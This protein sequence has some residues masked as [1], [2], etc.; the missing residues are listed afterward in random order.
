MD[1]FLRTIQAVWKYKGKVLASIVCAVF[2]SALWSLNFSA[3]YPIIKVLF[4]NDSLQS[5]V[6]TDIVRV[7][8]EIDEYNR[9]LAESSDTNLEHRDRLLKKLHTSSA[10]LMDRKWFKSKILPW[11]PNEK[12]NTVVVILCALIV[13]TLMKG[14]FLYIQEL[15][16]GSF[17]FHT[18]N[19]I[20]KNAFDNCS[21]LDIQSLQ[22][23]GTAEV[24]S[25]LTNDVTVMSD[26]YRLCGTVLIR[27]PLK[28]ICCVVAAMWFNWRLTS[29]SILTLPL[30]GLVFYQTGRRLRRVAIG[31]MER[32]GNIY[33]KIAETFDSSRVM[34]THNS[35]SHH[36]QQL[37]QANRNFYTDSMRLIRAGAVIKPSTEL[38][39]VIGFIAILAPGAYLVLNATDEIGGVKLASGP[40]TIAELTT[41][42]VLMAGVLDPMRKLSSVFPVAK[43][44]LAA[45]DRI[46]AITDKESLVVE[47]KN[48]VALPTDWNQISFEDIHFQYESAGESLIDRSPALNGVDLTIQRGQVVAVVG[49][50]G[51]GKSTLLSLLSRLMD[52][53]QGTVRLGD[54]DIKD[55]TLQE[56]RDQIAVV[57]QETTLFDETVLDNIQYGNFQASRET[58]IDAIRQA[59]AFDFVEKLPEGLE[60]ELGEGG[61]RLSGGQRQRIALARAIVRDPQILILDEATSA[62]D[63][64]SEDLIHG[65]LQSFCKDRTVFM[66]S[67]LLSHSFLD[68]VDRI[69]VMDAGQI[70]ADGTHESLMKSS[71]HYQ[72]LLRAPEQAPRTAA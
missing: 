50:N 14:V 31:T 63:A 48:P 15:L 59:H 42:Y 22:S 25:R 32:M 35:Q 55:F 44:S 64:E 26:G 1:S 28:A 57:S 24:T 7:E 69:I 33:K 34:I 18:A 61:R 72:R 46:F 45:A 62:I 65:A 29:I 49:G 20:R 43:K 58:M 27:E 53:Q 3:T 30:M 40:L 9:R 51:S 66:I 5:Y 36:S 23:L 39:G 12:F 68:L 54:V 11:I 52:A 2:V 56:L 10:E 41:L 17:V 19:D 70:V 47:T 8:A 60:T 37:Q 16:V 4:E 38:L 6:D 13:A 71:D 21:R 67:H